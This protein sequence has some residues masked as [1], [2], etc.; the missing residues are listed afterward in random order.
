MRSPYAVQ[1]RHAV[2]RAV[3]SA[4]EPAACTLLDSGARNAVLGAATRP[5]FGDYQ[6]NVAM[7]L[8][9]LLKASPRDVASE[10]VGQLQA[11]SQFS[12][13]CDTPTVAGPGFINLRLSTHA[14]AAGLTAM[15]SSSCTGCS[16]VGGVGG[17]GAGVGVGVGSGGGGGAGGRAAIPRVFEPK[18]VVVDYS[19]P[20]AAKEMHVGHL[21]STLIGDTLANVHEI[22]GHSVLRLNHVGD[23]GLQF[24]MLLAHVE[25]AGG[26]NGNVDGALQ[27]VNRCS[28]LGELYRDAKRCFDNPGERGDAFRARSRRA[29]LRL[30][31]GEPEAKAVWARLCERSRRHAAEVYQILGVHGLEERGESWYAERI[32]AMLQ[33]LAHRGLLHE[34]PDGALCVRRGSANFAGERAGAQVPEEPP[35]QEHEERLLVLQRHDGA[36]LYATTDLAA[37]QHRVQDELAERILYVTDAGQAGHFEDF[38]GVGKDAG[39]VPRGVDLLHVPFGVVQGID[40]KRFR[41]RDGDTVGLML[42][43]EEAVR[44]ARCEYDARLLK[45]GRAEDTAHREIVAR[46]MGIGAVRYAELSTRRTSDYVFSFEKM[47]ALNGNTAPYVLYVHA[48]IQSIL[49][50]N[51]GGMNSVHSTIRDSD[52][53]LSHRAELDLAHQLVKLPDAVWA[54]EESLLPSTLCEY[55]FETCQLYNRFYECCPVLGAA[56]GT[57]MQSR[58]ALCEMTAQVLRT[59]LDLLGIK[60]LDRI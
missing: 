9:K 8:A 40:G 43:L 38:F 12:A 33:D 29:V 2:E 55:A 46:S 30:Q 52:F 22:L 14:V 26:G 47:L 36:S 54:V 19:S 45:E 16:G 11:D 60:P 42:L 28:E 6:S 24:G 35:E 17:A 49:R 53:V 41:T 7:P 50:Q 13:I 31:N 4:F 51:P 3:C 15:A 57:I 39:F 10:V 48:R 37:L 23:W 32:P 44:V 21:R 18:R 20:N 25:D 5:E 56:D 27:A 58:L 34:Q 59:L 1:L